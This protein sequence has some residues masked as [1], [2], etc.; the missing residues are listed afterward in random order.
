MWNKRIQTH[1]EQWLKRSN[2]SRSSTKV[3]NHEATET[4]SQHIC[5]NCRSQWSRGLRRRSEAVRLLRLWVRI[6]PGAWMFVCCEC[7][8]LSGRGLC[9]GLITRPV[10]SYRLWCVVV[11]D[12]GNLKN[13]EAMAR[14]GPQRHKKKKELTASAFSWLIMLKLLAVCLDI[15]HAFFIILSSDMEDILCTSPV[16]FEKTKLPLYAAL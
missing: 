10:E 11:C 14:V 3:S 8:V 16:F 1:V 6:P 15:T 12:L 9:D 13:E 4:I 7:C 2:I 5:T